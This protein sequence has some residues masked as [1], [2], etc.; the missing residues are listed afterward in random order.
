MKC[1]SMCR[2]QKLEFF[3]EV[4]GITFTP[5]GSTFMAGLQENR[6]GGFLQYQQSVA[7]VQRRMAE[8]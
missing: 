6:H 1:A 3:S 4:A 7:E 5:D 2:A 8:S